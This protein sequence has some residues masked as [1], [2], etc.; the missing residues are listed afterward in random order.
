MELFDVVEGRKDKPTERKVMSRKDRKMKGLRRKEK[1][2]RKRWRKVVQ[3]S[4]SIV[5]GFLSSIS[6]FEGFV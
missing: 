3:I 6:D 1:K 2:I 4:L 5:A